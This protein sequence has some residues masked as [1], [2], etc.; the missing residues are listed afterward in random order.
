MSLFESEPT[1]HLRPEILSLPAYK[2]GRPAPANAAINCSSCT[3]A[4][5]A[6]RESERLAIE[7]DLS[8]QYAS[9][10]RMEAVYPSRKFNW[11]ELKKASIELG[12]KAKDIFDPNFKS[13]KAY[14]AA[15]WRAVYSIDTTMEPA[16]A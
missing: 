1:V 9:V 16:N 12:L 3:S 5:A 11:R 10:K 13:V 15:V 6:K 4:A 14:H 7:L 8:K 2:Q